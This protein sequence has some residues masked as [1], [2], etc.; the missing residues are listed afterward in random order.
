MVSRMGRLRWG[1][2]AMILQR[3][4]R[5]ITIGLLRDSHTTPARV[6]WQW[7]LWDFRTSWFKHITP[8]FV[9]HERRIQ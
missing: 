7:V 9:S 2:C 8:K 5:V 6:P 4:F 1:L 3:G